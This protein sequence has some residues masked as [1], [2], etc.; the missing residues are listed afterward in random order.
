[1]LLSSCFS[2]ELSYR[3]HRPNAIYHRVHRSAAVLAQVLQATIQQHD[4][5]EP[6]VERARGAHRHHPHRDHNHHLQ[7]RRAVRS[8]ITDYNSSHHVKA[9]AFVASSFH[10]H[11]SIA[12]DPIAPA[13]VSSRRT[14]W[15]SHSCSAWRSCASQAPFC[16]KSGCSSRAVSPPSRRYH[17]VRTQRILSM[18]KELRT[19]LTS[20]LCS[21]AATPEEP[22]S[23]AHLREALEREL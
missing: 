14:S 5:D 23:R 8:L 21:R 7:E 1:M 2:L 13:A 18:L 9:F 19:F 11:L 12:Y 22:H 3:V 4:R 6:E 16:Q 10:T 15:S 17:T 20:D